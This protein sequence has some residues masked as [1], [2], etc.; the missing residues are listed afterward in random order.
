MSAF[1]GKEIS[2]RTGIIFPPLVFPARRILR[3]V[4]WQAKT[5]QQTEADG[6]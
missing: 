5:V 3:A 2:V 1:I 4:T 6:L